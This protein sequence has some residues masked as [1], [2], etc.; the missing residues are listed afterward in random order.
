MRSV[1]FLMEAIQTSQLSLHDVDLLVEEFLS[2][3]KDSIQKNW[4]SNNKTNIVGYESFLV[5]L[6]PL[7]KNSCITFINAGL[8]PSVLNSYLF[9]TVLTAARRLKSE[10]IKKVAMAICPAHQFLNVDEIVTGNKIYKC[11]KC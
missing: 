6:R 8:E 3:N 1:S 10:D 9:P 7:L 5:E 2:N 11:Q 4:S